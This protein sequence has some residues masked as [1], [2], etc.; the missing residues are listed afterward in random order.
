[1]L[2][3]FDCDG[4]LIDSEWLA[5]REE[6]RLLT[7]F[8][9]QTTP[10]EIADRYVGIRAADMLAD[11]VRRHG[12]Q[13][14]PEYHAAAKAR[15]DEVFANE[16]EAIP[17]ISEALEALAAVPRC[18]ASSSAPSRLRSNLS[19]VGLLDRFEPHLFS[20]T[21][22]ER[23]KPA[24]DLFHL[25][26][27]SMDCAPEA[28]IVVEDSEAGVTGAVAAGMYVIGFVG[29]KHCGPDHAERLRAAG[30]HEILEDMVNLP[31]LTQISHS[32]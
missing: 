8:G 31:T 13:I 26:A 20:G 24:P 25:A 30:A 29:G 11:I 2:L 32:R 21:M 5:C 9:F 3:I 22:V 18:V 16:L 27:R 17:G 12:R 19:N 10:E 28:C 7:D 1:M 23:G 14:P 4:V 6:A 15:F